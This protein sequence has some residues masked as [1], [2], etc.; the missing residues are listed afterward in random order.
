MIRTVISVIVIIACIACFLPHAPEMLCRARWTIFSN[1]LHLSKERCEHAC[2]LDDCDPEL[3]H[4]AGDPVSDF[5]FFIANQTNLC[6]HP[7]TLENARNAIK[8]MEVQRATCEMKH[9]REL[10]FRKE[11]EKKRQEVIKQYGYDVESF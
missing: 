1:R 9:Q 4:Y 11:F 2:S 5:S 7:T 3:C 8:W 6:V 10:L